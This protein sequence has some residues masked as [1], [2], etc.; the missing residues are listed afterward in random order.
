M[1]EA[2]NANDTIY[3]DLQRHLDKQ[4]V[5][6][7][8]SKS[9]AELRILRRIFTP[10]EARL[11]LHLSYKPATPEIVRER[12]EAGGIPGDRVEEMLESMVR[13][14]GIER[15]EKEGVRQYRTMPFV[16][17][18]YEHQLTRLTPEF[19]AD[20][21]EYTSDRAFG[22]SFLAT[23]R[24]QMRTVPVNKSLTIEHHVATYDHV[25]DLINDAEG[26]FAI[27]ECICRK[28]AAMRGDPCKKTSRQ[29]SCMPIGDMARLAIEN[30]EGR[31]IGREE[32]LEIARMAEEE[33]LVFQPSNTQK[34]DFICACCGCCCGMLS[35]HKMLPKPV[36]FWAT[37]YYAAVDA[38]ACTGCGVCVDRCQ[39]NAVSVDG[40]GSIARI[41]LDRCIGC[42]NCV[43]TCPTDALSLVRKETETVPPVDSEALHDEIMAH[44]KGTIGKMMLVAKLMMKR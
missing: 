9:G 19:L 10:E 12:A 43:V 6:F 7:P 2:M 18:I 20:M 22:L 32:A 33:G 34:A 36:D 29:E 14:G 35:L 3:R 28:T 5:G 24:P 1:S 38:E 4:P 13:K 21:R 15:I 8:A 44:K 17:G 42:G 39:V 23:E 30:G 40:N 31:E 25:V 11:A 16:V 37:N 26:P 41:N 27:L